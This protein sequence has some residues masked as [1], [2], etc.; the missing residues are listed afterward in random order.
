[1]TKPWTP[2]YELVIVSQLYARPGA[3]AEV[4]AALRANA[5]ATHEEPG[6]CASPPTRTRATRAA[7]C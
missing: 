6:A 1:M 3:E 2:G 5:E 7:S 4:I